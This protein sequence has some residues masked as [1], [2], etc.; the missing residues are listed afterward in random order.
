MEDHILTG[1]TA[2][3]R[4]VFDDDEL[5]LKPELTADDVDGW[6]SLSHI[7]LILSVQKKFGVKFSPVEMNRLKNVGD[8]IALTRAKQRQGVAP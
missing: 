1:L 4:E 7:R 6:D 3:F 2:V 8:L 5:V